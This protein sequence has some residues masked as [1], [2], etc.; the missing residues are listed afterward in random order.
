MGHRIF[1][2][3]PYSPGGK[4]NP[5]GWAP[6]APPRSD[7]EK[8]SFKFLDIFSFGYFNLCRKS[9]IISNVLTLN[10]SVMATKAATVGVYFAENENTVL[11]LLRPCGVRA[12]WAGIMVTWAE[13]QIG[14]ARTY[15]NIIKKLESNK[16]AFLVGEEV[17]FINLETAKAWHLVRFTCLG[18]FL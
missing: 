3:C 7:M 11:V 16:I 1:P 13:Y 10:V 2:Y 8:N 9:H 6:V 4:E 18:L 5:M 17:K 14:T 12:P 15:T